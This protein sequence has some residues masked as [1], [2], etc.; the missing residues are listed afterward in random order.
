MKVAACS[1]SRLSFCATRQEENDSMMDPRLEQGLAPRERE[2]LHRLWRA[3][4]A[5]T[6]RPTRRDVLRWSTIAAGAVAT[7]R[8]GIVSAAPARALRQDAQYV[9]G[10]EIT[11]PFD[12]FGQEITLDPHRSSDYGGFWVVYP[13]VWG[14]FLRYDEMGRIALDLAEK[15]V[16]SQDG[17]RYTLTIREGATYANGSPVLAD[18]FVTSWM[19]ALDPA[20]LSPMVAFMEPV[21]GFNDWIGGN[22]DAQPGFSTED[23]RTVVIELDEP[24]TYFPSFLA[25]F[26]WAV[27]DPQ[28]LA[29]FGDTN[30]VLNGAGTGPWEF[31]EYQQNTQFVMEPNSHY[32][33]AVSPSLVKITWPVFN[34]PDAASSALDLY[35]KEN[36]ASAD[37]PLSLL[38]GVQGDA[39]LNGELHQL[40]QA[41]AT[42]RSLAMDFRQAPFNDVRVRRAFGLAFDRD[43]YSQIYAGT[44][45]PATVFT[46]PAV[47]ELSGY[48]PPDGFPF[49]VAQAQSLLAEAGFPNG[50]GLPE[51]TFYQPS[52][53]SDEELQRIQQVLQIFQDNLGVA[54]T[55]D[56]S[57]TQEQINQLIADNGGLQFGIMWWQTVTDT[58]FLLS[59]VFRPESPYMKGVFNWAPD[60]EATGGDPGAAAAQFADLVAQAD[61]ELDAAKRNDLYRQAET[62]VLDNAVYV[63][64]A[65]WVPMYVQKPW[66]QGTKQGPWT[67]RLPILF[68]KDVIVAPH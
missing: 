33:D 15:V 4:G 8:H 65:N 58:P 27:V 36:A 5:S 68:D 51:I 10:A 46:P 64:I 44:W 67:G 56:N 22:T 48:E 24:S 7:A 54:I 34:G 19:R 62:L 14:G 63:P 55:L 28:A 29:D 30:F 52:G 53:D 37:V 42:I 38:A 20:N 31:T 16:R 18:H 3:L 6:P 66:L 25:S 1:S 60:L 13:N 41:Q 12:A 57:R 23:D 50:E 59:D 45:T 43:R 32:F 39:T 21:R 17:L 2:E 11:V 49:D 61:V 9:E 26:V 35:Q 47:N 40:N